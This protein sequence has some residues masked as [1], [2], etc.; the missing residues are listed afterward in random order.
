MHKFKV[1]KSNIKKVFAPL[2]DS[3]AFFPQYLILKQTNINIK[4]IHLANTKLFSN[5][6]FI[7]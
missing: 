2:E 4:K 5:A 7:Y 1:T 3:F 6:K